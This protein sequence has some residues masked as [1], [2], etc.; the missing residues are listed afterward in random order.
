MHFVLPTD[1]RA[2]RSDLA[3]DFVSPA[4][5]E[6]LVD[7]PVPPQPDDCNPFSSD[8]VRDMIRDVISSLNVT[9]PGAWDLADVV[10]ILESRNLKDESREQTF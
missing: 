8:A 4:A 9:H 3:N 6:K 10:R 1:E 5:A 7:A 2:S